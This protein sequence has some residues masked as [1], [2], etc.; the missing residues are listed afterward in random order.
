MPRA[1]GRVRRTLSGIRSQEA[2]P[3]RKPNR[4][5]TTEVLVGVVHAGNP[6]PT[7]IEGRMSSPSPPQESRSYP[8]AL[9]RLNR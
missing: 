9:P 8:V 2:S 7:K 6:C 5:L 4:K 1:A 3:E